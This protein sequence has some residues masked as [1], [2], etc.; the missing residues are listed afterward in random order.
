MRHA[1]Y[2]EAVDDGARQGIDDRHVAAVFMRHIHPRRE[3]GHAFGNR[4]HDGGPHVRRRRVTCRAG[5]HLIAARGNHRAAL[6]APDLKAT[7]AQLGNRALGGR[8]EDL[9]GKIEADVRRWAPI[10]QA[11]NLKAE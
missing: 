1:T 6:A 11:L 3:V 10:V 9:T 4:A 5:G 8:P 2:C 7:L